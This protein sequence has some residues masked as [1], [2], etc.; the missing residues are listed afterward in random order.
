[1]DKESLFVG[2]PEE[3]EAFKQATGWD[4]DYYPTKTLLELAE[5]IAGAEAYVGNQ[6]LG[7][8]IAIGLGVEFYCEERRDLP[9][10]RNE[11]FFPQQPNGF[12]F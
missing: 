11:C 7:L 1:M 6:S 8:S 10:E 12:Y 9:M 3:Y 4:I 5:I 2:L